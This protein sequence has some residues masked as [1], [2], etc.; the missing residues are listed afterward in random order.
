MISM[1]TSRHINGQ[2]SMLTKVLIPA[3]SVLEAVPANGSQS[4]ALDIGETSDLLVQFNLNYNSNGRG[5]KYVSPLFEVIHHAGEFPPVTWNRQALSTTSSGS[6]TPSIVQTAFTDG[7]KTTSATMLTGASKMTY[8][9]PHTAAAST[10]RSSTT[11]ATASILKSMETSQISNSNT[12]SAAAIGLVVGITFAIVAV[13]LIG[14]QYR[15]KERKESDHRRSLGISQTPVMFVNEKR[16]VGELD[17]H[18]RQF[19]LSAGGIDVELD[20]SRSTL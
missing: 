4:V 15:K 20:G 1:F 5:Q 16:T 11:S 14:F 10:G 6:L 8:P 7:S 9:N 18:Q 17:A 2:Y 13:G 3:G 12:L 19:E